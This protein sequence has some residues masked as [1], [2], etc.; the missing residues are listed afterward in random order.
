MYN[1]ITNKLFSYVQY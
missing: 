1:I